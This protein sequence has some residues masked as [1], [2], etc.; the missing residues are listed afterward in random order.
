M[1]ILGTRFQAK[2]PCAHAGQIL[3]FADSGSATESSDELQNFPGGLN[4]FADFLIQV[5]EGGFEGFAV[6]RV[7]GRFQIVNDSDPGEL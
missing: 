4:D 5:G 2:G 7:G 1:K 3:G 6:L